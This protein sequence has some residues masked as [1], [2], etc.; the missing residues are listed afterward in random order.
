MSLQEPATSPC[1]QPDESIPHF[2]PLYVLAIHFNIIL[3]ATSTTLESVSFRVSNQNIVRM[4]HLPHATQ[5][6]GPFRI[7]YLL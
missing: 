4:S 5:I 2:H 3:R 7:K 1:L 6:P